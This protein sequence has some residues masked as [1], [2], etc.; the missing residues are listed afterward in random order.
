MTD[1]RSPRADVSYGRNS[2]RKGSSIF[3]IPDRTCVQPDEKGNPMRRFILQAG[4]WTALGL[5]AA[6]AV[7]S[8]NSSHRRAV[9]AAP[10]AKATVAA[11]SVDNCTSSDACCPTKAS[12]APATVAARKATP[13]KVAARVSRPAGVGG[14]VIALDPATGELG[15]PSAEQMAELEAV[16]DRTIPVDETDHAGPVTTV[17][18]ADGSVTAHLNGGYQEFATVHKAPNGKLS[19]GCAD[20]PTLPTTQPAPSALEEK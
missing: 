11:A 20:A 2:S 18:N 4:A 9:T 5:V 14:L 3:R 8:A 10:A 13:T 19:F 6:F 7:V 15:M 12:V 17:R 16:Q 1:K